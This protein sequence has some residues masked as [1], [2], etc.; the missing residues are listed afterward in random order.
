MM[1]K[2]S[3]AG[4]STAVFTGLYLVAA[5][6]ANAVEA[7]ESAVLPT[8]AISEIKNDQTTVATPLLVTSASPIAISGKV[9]VALTFFTPRGLRP[10]DENLRIVKKIHKQ[11]DI[12]LFL[13]GAVLGSFRLPNSKENYSGTSIKNIEHPAKDIFIPAVSKLTDAWVLENAPAAEPYKNAMLIRPDRML[14]VYVDF[15]EENPKY[16]FYLQTTLSRAPDSRSF[17]S[18]TAP[19]EITCADKYSEPAL[20]LDQWQANDYAELRERIKRHIDTC[21]PQ[22]KTGLPLML[23][24]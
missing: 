2:F 1:K 16:D 3:R 24:A 20:D 10:A 21:L 17:L 22:I 19:P 23:A 5:S 15:E 6:N 8:L 7:D 4:L 11:Q 9:P 13:L 12:G 14:L 18:F